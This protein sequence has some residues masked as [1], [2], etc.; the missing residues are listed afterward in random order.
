MKQ[1]IIGLLKIYSR[2][3]SHLTYRG[4]LLEENLAYP[5]TWD[6]LPFYGIGMVYRFYQRL[7]GWFVGH[8]LSETEHDYGGGSHVG[9]YC[10]WCDKYF[11]IPKEE[12]L[13]FG[14]NRDL[15]D[16]V[17]SNHEDTK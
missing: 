5:Q 13:W 9:Q 6:C 16:M 8:E 15:V 7:C 1:L 4:E 12:S 17:D 14:E 11:S 3:H 2:T 10:R